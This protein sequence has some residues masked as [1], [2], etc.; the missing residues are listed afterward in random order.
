MGKDILAIAQDLVIGERG[1]AYGHP[2]EDFSKTAKIWSAILGIEVTPAQVG[3]CMIGVKISR[4]VFKHKDDNL[5]DVCGYAKT[6]QMVYEREKELL[7][8][9]E[10]KFQ[11]KQARLAEEKGAAGGKRK[12]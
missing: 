9:G 2:H 12:N 11:E 8:W 7:E 6:I 3:L 1:G 10:A 4:E 5:V